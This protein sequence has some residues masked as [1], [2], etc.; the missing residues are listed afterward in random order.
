[1]SRWGSA[2]RRTRNVARSRPIPEGDHE[3]YLQDFGRIFLPAAEYAESLTVMKGGSGGL[4]AADPLE[5]LD[6]ANECGHG[7]LPSDPGPA[8]S[9]WERRD[10]AT[11]SHESVGKSVDPYRGATTEVENDKG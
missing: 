2:P 3:R 10:P 8:C 11:K 9:C 6:A 1:M 5:L 4:T 7:R